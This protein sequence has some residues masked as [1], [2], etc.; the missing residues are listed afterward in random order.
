MKFHE[1]KSPFQIWYSKPSEY[2]GMDGEDKVECWLL[3]V[4]TIIGIYKQS[5]G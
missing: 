3:I 1:E 2:Y 5:L 4:W